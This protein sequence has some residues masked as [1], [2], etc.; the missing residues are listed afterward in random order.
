MYGDSCSVEDAST[1]SPH[2]LHNYGTLKPMTFPQGSHNLPGLNF[3]LKFDG[4]TD[5]EHACRCVQSQSQPRITSSHRRKMTEQGFN[6]HLSLVNHACLPDAVRMTP[7]IKK[8]GRLSVRNKE[9]ISCV[10]EGSKKL[11]C[12]CANTICWI[13]NSMVDVLNIESNHNG[14]GRR[15]LFRFNTVRKTIIIFTKEYRLEF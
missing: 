2:Q 5:V 8:G 6:L 1:I 4:S 12:G 3:P 13:D 9:S 14:G 11:W 15:N 10:V 7:R